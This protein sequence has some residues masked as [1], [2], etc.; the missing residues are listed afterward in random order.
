MLRAWAIE[1]TGSH[2]AGLSRHLLEHS[3]IVVEL[4]RPKRAARHNGA[5]IRSMRSAPRVKRWPGRGWER[6][7]SR[8][9]HRRPAPEVDG[10]RRAAG[11]PS[12]TH[13]HAHR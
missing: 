1:A 6:P 7:P 11:A 10:F 13:I 2:G 5:T 9:R 12:I 4:D 3:E 8:V